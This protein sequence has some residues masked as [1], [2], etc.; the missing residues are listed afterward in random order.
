V[1]FLGK[2]NAETRSFA[3]SGEDRIIKFLF[4]HQLQIARPTYIDIGA[5]HASELSNTYL[6]YLRGSRGVLV[7]P[8]PAL[9]EELRRRRRRDTCLNIGIS[10]TGQELT[11]FVMHPDTLST[12]LQEEAELHRRDYG[13]KIMRTINVE[14][15]PVSEV[16]EEHFP[17]GVNLVSLDAE[18]FDDA[19]LGSFP[20]ERFRP[21]VFCVE[22]AS[23][24]EGLTVGK[25]HA[26]ADM[27]SENGYF[28][29]ADTFVNTIFVDERAWKSRK[30]PTL[31]AGIRI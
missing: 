31:T 22:T 2:L 24:G 11:F 16:L 1:R 23:Y 7:E 5:Y 14:T 19:I 4:D 8:D 15:R 26:I 9:C 17:Q 10:P 18:G 30:L 28:I 12:F 3:Q 20:F 27:M 29:Y 6:L 25:D 21:E 13:A